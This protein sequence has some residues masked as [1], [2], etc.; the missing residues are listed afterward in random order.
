M[1]HSKFSTHEANDSEG[2]MRHSQ[3]STYEADGSEGKD[4]AQPIRDVR[5]H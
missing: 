2:K 1:R 3:F 4:A 5:A